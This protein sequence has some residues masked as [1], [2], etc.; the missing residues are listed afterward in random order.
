[1]TD[2]LVNETSA[3][4]LRIFDVTFFLFIERFEPSTNRQI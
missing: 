1:M 4:I 3:L 2:V